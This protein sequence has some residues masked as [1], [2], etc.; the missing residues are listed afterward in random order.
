VLGGATAQGLGRAAERRGGGPRMADPGYS[1]DDFEEG[2][3]TYGDDGFDDD[4][5]FDEVPSSAQ[6]PIELRDSPHGVPWDEGGASTQSSDSISEG[7]EA[8]R[9][10]ARG[11]GAAAGGAAAADLPHA[12]IPPRTPPGARR[13]LPMPENSPAARPG[14]TRRTLLPTAG[15]GAEP[16]AASPADARPWYV[17]D[18]EE[19]S[20]GRL[21]GYGM[22]PVP[23]PE[24]PPP[25]PAPVQKTLSE[26]PPMTPALLVKP[27]CFH[28][29]EARNRFIVRLQRVVRGHFSRRAWVKPIR[30]LLSWRKHI[31]HQQVSA[32]RPMLVHILPTRK[33]DEE[34]LGENA[35]C[36]HI[37]VPIGCPDTVKWFPSTKAM[38]TWWYGVP[39]KVRR[40]FDTSQATVLPRWD[41]APKEDVTLAVMPPGSLGDAPS[42]GPGSYTVNEKSEVL[43]PRVTGG[44]FP[45]A[46]RF[47]QAA[48]SARGLKER[49]GDGKGSSVPI[50]SFSKMAPHAPH[51]PR[52]P[53]PPQGAGRDEGGGHTHSKVPRL[54]L[55]GEGA[56]DMDI[57]VASARI[58]KSVSRAPSQTEQYKQKMVTLAQRQQAVQQRLADKEKEEVEAARERIAQLK[59]DNSRHLSK[60]RSDLS[61]CRHPLYGYGDRF[62]MAFVS[63]RAKIGWRGDKAPAWATYKPPEQQQG[64]SDTQ[65]GLDHLAPLSERGRPGPAK[66]D[67]FS[68]L[69]TITETSRTKVK[70]PS[71][72]S[73]AAALATKY[74]GIGAKFANLDESSDVDPLSL[75]PEQGWSSTS[76]TSPTGKSPADKSPKAKSPA[77]GGA[78]HCKTLVDVHERKGERRGDES[79]GQQRMGP[80]TPAP[81]ARARPARHLG[82]S[83]A[84]PAVA[85]LDAES[86]AQERKAG[87]VL[88]AREEDA[89]EP[90][91]QHA[92]VV[93]PPALPASGATVEANSSDLRARHL[94]ARDRADET[95]PVQPPVVIAPEPAPAPVAAPAPSAEPSVPAPEE[96]VDLSKMT[97]VQRMKYLAAQ[98]DKQDASAAALAASAAPLAPQPP[99]PRM[100]GSRVPVSLEGQ[101]SDDSSDDDDF[102]SSRAAIKQKASACR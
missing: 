43:H 90:G 26:T 47:G 51:A 55:A 14:S 39:D 33:Q 42:L 29:F 56:N 100:T 35:R 74:E 101:N 68:L 85:K 92:P 30:E 3:A 23:S 61:N 69:A 84:S 76:P 93:P 65:A 22:R 79:G 37:L 71:V 28:K 11:G 59:R 34:W 2:D 48:Q 10:R 89:A 91:R 46:A 75:L 15:A 98:K 31:K 62:S 94:R 95:L 58:S 5:D 99:A 49:G 17:R 52:Q 57:S 41:D 86:E 40:L 1:E 20:S 77:G 50:K 70:D 63:P 21:P 66:K 64:G 8:L 27:E 25:P 32:R 45:R 16:A 36:A 73:S 6:S 87:T 83:A 18:E 96:A 80:K 60:M 44:N 102:V 24:M 78:A 82:S 7:L 53:S 13:P 88:G 12:P 67:F 54:K 72:S 4:V 19:D 38:K 9:A 97:R 81:K